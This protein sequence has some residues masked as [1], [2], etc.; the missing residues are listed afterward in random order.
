MRKSVMVTKEKNFLHTIRLTVLFVAAGIMLFTSLAIAQTDT[1]WSE[2]WEDSWSSDWHITF[3]TWE[4]GDPTSGPGSA[5]SELNCAATILSGNYSNDVDSTRL[6]RHTSFVVPT[7][8]ENPRLRFWH[9]YSFTI[10]DSDYGKVQ[11]KVAGAQNWEDLSDGF[12]H[13]WSGGIWTRPFIDLSAYAGLSV[14]IAFYFHSDGGYV[15]AGWY[16]DDINILP[17]IVGIDDNLKNNIPLQFQLSP[18]YPN[19][20]NPTTSIN[21]QLPKT[22]LVNI[23]VY[24]IIGQKIKTLLNEQKPAGAY[25]V[26]W[27]GTDQAGKQVSS[28][29]YL[30]RLWVSTPSGKSVEF[31]QTKKMV[32]VR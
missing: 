21:Y 22:G 7:A 17:D 16:I 15:E 26:I 13:D 20:F 19:P 31:M 4:V 27:D 14:Q 1:L 29:V 3:G 12:Y 10:N 2:N 23:S 28:G 25:Q 9:W 32:L 5:H 8:N 11:I 24:N 6:I 30:Y 18:N